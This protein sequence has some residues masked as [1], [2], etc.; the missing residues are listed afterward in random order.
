M[1]SFTR[2]MILAAVLCLAASRGL[3][4][5]CQGHDLFP[6]LKSEAPASYAAIETAASA[7][8]FRHGKL[9]LLSRAGSKPSYVFATLHLSDPR[10][11]SFS[12]RLRAA[13]MDSKIVA[14]EFVETGAV[15]RGVIANN[16]AKWRRVTVAGDNQRA[17]GLLDKTDFAHLEALADRKGHAKS[18]VHTFKPSVLALL[19]DLPSCATGLPGA[20]T[21]VDELVADIARKNKIPMVGL[22]SMIE[23]LEVLDG[24]PRETSRDLL[25]AIL[26][27]ADRAED[28]VETMVARYTE[29][30]IGGS[31]AWL[32][33]AEP[34]PGVKQAQIPQA[35]V[36]RLITVRNQRMRDRALP[37][38]ERGGA[39][40]AAGAA[41]LPG[42][43]GLLSLFESAGFKVEA[44]E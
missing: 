36:D 32:R 39:F 26:R 7:M 42:K 41:H 18:A 30:D 9:F 40:I 12:P 35:F 4:A 22:E 27:Q 43:E 25:T 38:L 1:V 17:D 8:P 23:Q 19:L 15:L 5:D 14:L 31:L 34:I 29:G 44:I 10:I 13:L 2:A 33:S 24:L 37:L 21:Y 11:T 20:T 6:A 3:A 16:G 28:I